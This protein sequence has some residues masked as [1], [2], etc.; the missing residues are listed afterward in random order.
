MVY[1]DPRL[2]GKPAP[3]AFVAMMEGDHTARLGR[4]K[5]SNIAFLDQ[6]IPAYRREIINIIGMGLTEKV[7]DTNLA[8]KIKAPAHGFTVTM[9][10]HAMDAGRRFIGTRPRRSF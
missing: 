1:V 2:R 4:A 10:G 3:A 8:P 6:K 9:C 5:G 7:T